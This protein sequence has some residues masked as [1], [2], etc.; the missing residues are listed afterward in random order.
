[1]NTRHTGKSDVAVPTFSAWLSQH[2]AGQCLV[3][4]LAVLAITALQ[5]LDVTKREPQPAMKELCARVRRAV[6]IIDTASRQF[7]LA[8][9]GRTW[10]S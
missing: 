4:A 9:N 7:P 6:P 5:A 8:A 3:S 10:F 2:E 1:M